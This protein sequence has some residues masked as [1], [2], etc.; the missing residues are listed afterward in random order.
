M[1]AWDPTTNAPD[2][3]AGSKVVPDNVKELATHAVAKASA[4]PP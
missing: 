3:G 2:I 1:L 4:C